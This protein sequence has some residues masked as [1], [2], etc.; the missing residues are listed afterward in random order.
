M[1]RGEHQAPRE[2]VLEVARDPEAREHAAERGRLEEHEDE[3]E[4]RVARGEV[5][6]RQPRQLRE[7]AHER[8]E[9]E[10]RECDRRDEDVRRRERVVRRPPGDAERD[11]AIR[12][13]RSSAHV[14]AILT[15]SACD[16]TNVE[17]TISA[18]ATDEPER[19]RLEVPAGDDEAAHGLDEVR[20]RVGR[21]DRAEPVDLHEVP[22][23]VHRRH[24]QED[25]QHGEE[26]LDRLARAGAQR[27]EGAEHPEAGRDERGEHE[28]HDDAG[29][30]RLDLDAE[31]ERAAEIED[32]LDEA[33]DDHAG[34]VA[35]EEG[36]AA[37]R[38]QGEPVEEAVL[39]VPREI[40]PR[41]HR[42][43][44]RALD[45]RHGDGEGE[46]RVGGKAVELRSTA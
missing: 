35:G 18:S 25:E 11:R 34:E 44:Q 40:R 43:E 45:E 8:R 36:A 19:E 20:D 13:P 28:D 23:R 42:R 30:A 10:E 22:R 6:P 37:H 21:R 4:R 5:E 17:T 26:R 27:H 46:E 33:H 38:R 3:L 29:H 24:E 9:E 39:D 31:R 7:A 14:R 1:R 41:V 12:V 16:A 32:G 2:P 15:R